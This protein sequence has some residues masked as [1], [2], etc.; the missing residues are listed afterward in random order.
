MLQAEPGP[1]PPD[2]KVSLASA[3]MAVVIAAA[4]SS[5]QDSPVYMGGGRARVR[6]RGPSKSPNRVTS[7][8]GPTHDKV[9][10]RRCL[11]SNSPHCSRTAEIP[12]L[13][14]T[15]RDKDAAPA[16]PEVGPLGPQTRPAQLDLPQPLPGRGQEAAPSPLRSQLSLLPVLGRMGSP[17][18]GSQGDFWCYGAARMGRK[19]LPPPSRWPWPDACTG[20]LLMGERLGAGAQDVL[21]LLSGMSGGLALPRDRGCQALPSLWWHWAGMQMP[22]LILTLGSWSSSKAS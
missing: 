3:L 12:T 17:W 19:L 7:I 8:K 5:E 9:L 2:P 1:S 21:V 14:M 18:L 11:R 13:Q 15:S 4:R 10:C 16:H 20:S 6:C 22:Q